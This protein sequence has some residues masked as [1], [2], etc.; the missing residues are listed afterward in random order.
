MH[1]FKSAILTIFQLWQNSTFDPV[2]FWPKH[3]FWSSMKIT[4]TKNIANMSHSPRSKLYIPALTLPFSSVFFDSFSITLLHSRKNWHSCLLMD[5]TK[6]CPFFTT[7]WL[8]MDPKTSCLLMDPNQDFPLSK[9]HV[10]WWT[11]FLHIFS[12]FSPL[13]PHVFWWTH[14]STKTSCLFMDPKPHVF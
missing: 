6:F 10:I 2:L 11:Q 4:S 5:P 12:K 7:S 1:G 9:S 13:K 14:Y 8:L 3:F